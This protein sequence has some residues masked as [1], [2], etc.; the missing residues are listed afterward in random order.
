M[1]D[2]P[3]K[4]LGISRDASKEEIKKAYRKK[5]KEYHPDLHPGDSAAARKM[6]DINE[7][8]D[9]LNHPEK[10]QKTSSTYGGARANYGT[11]QSSYYQGQGGYYG[12]G[13]QTGQQWNSDMHS[14][15]GDFGFDSFFGYRRTGWTQ[16]PLTEESWDS[17]EIR[18]AIRYVNQGQYTYARGILNQIVS[19]Q[20]NAR[21]Y[22][23]SALTYYGQGETR[24]ALEHIQ[25]AVQMEPENPVYQRTLQGFQQSGREY[26][27][28]EE[29]NVGRFMRRLLIG[30]GCFLLISYLLRFFWML[31]MFM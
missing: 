14:G 19:S 20:R 25:R 30:F 3:Y 5:A 6:N 18:Q 27:G 4:V 12:S 31:F 11:G 2:D 9:M 29:M 16:E 21:W 8:Y 22:Y 10:Y 15:Y 28:Y 1:I 24:W 7:A 13:Q 23:I 17:S 26:A